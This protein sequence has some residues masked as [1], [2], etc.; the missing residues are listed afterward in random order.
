M[1][2]DKEWRDRIKGILK[3]ELKR[4][5]VSYKQLADRLDGIGIHE[6]E[7]NI[8]NKISRGSFTAVFF[9]QCLL[10]VGVER[11]ILDSIDRS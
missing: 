5:N 3:A 2:T 1:P 11:L 6:S 4:R 10:A 8:N 9:L 7:K